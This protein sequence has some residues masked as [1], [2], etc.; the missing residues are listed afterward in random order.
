MGWQTGEFGMS[1]EGRA[2][3][4]LADGSEPEPAYFDIGSGGH[5][6]STTDWWVYDGTLGTRRAT[7]L[8]GACSCG[9]RGTR[10]YLID[11]ELVADGPGDADTSGPRADWKDHLGDVEARSVPLPG[12]LEGLLAQVDEQ[13]TA[14]ADDAPL[15]ALKAVAVLERATRRAGR[16]AARNAEADEVSWEAAGKALGMSPA[17]AGSLLTAHFPGH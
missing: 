8:R 9:W 2:A 10:T 6:P 11:W 12:G 5:V 1:H 15:A 14:L 17:E 13:L 7:R 16:A 3:A 4:L